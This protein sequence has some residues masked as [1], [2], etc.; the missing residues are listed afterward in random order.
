MMFTKMKDKKEVKKLEDDTVPIEALTG[1]G[2]GYN[3]YYFK[4]NSWYRE[5]GLTT[6]SAQKKFI[7]KLTQLFGQ[8]PNYYRIFE[9]KTAVWGFEWQGEKVLIYRSE[10]G[11]S[12]QLLSNFTPSKIKPFLDFMIQTLQVGHVKTP[13]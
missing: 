8:K 13:F 6:S 2:N 10:R 7:E 9:Y 5:H 4:I 12:I 11:L 1:Y 3:E